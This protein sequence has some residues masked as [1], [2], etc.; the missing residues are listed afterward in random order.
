M[1]E[2]SSHPAVAIVERMNPEQAMMGCGDG[3]DLHDGREVPGVVSFL[4]QLEESGKL[5]SWK[6]RE[7]RSHKHFPRPQLAWHNFDFFAGLGILV[8]KKIR[9]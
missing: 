5:G 2:E 4:K 9:G 8:Q 1:A 3:D 6:W 7:V